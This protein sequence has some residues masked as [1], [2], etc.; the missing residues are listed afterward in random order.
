MKNATNEFNNSITD[1]IG[2]NMK[3]KISFSKFRIQILDTKGKIVET[4]PVSPA[5]SAKFNFKIRI[6]SLDIEKDPE[7]KTK[8]VDV[9]LLADRKRQTSADYYFDE[10][11]WGRQR[12]HL[13]LPPKE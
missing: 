12:L 3:E 10:V 4:L 11:N 2:Q 9:V 8:Y 1:E 6:N 13:D 5:K 7:T